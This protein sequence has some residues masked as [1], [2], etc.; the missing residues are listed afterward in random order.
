MRTTVI[1][2]LKKIG[3]TH[4]FIRKLAQGKAN[5]DAYEPAGRL[6]AK[7]IAKV[8]KLEEEASDNPR[9]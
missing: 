9:G 1:R 4:E 3:I 5:Q 7:V 8:W 6:L 2:E